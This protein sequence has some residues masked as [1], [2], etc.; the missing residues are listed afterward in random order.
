M[1]TI[2][3][4]GKISNMPKAEYTAKFESARKIIEQQGYEVINPVQI[5]EEKYGEGVQLVTWEQCM[6]DVLPYLLQADAVVLLPCWVHSRGAKIEFR[7]AKEL[8]IPCLESYKEL[9]LRF[10]EKLY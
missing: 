8:G 10:Y 5:I 6:K 3:I 2:Y 1:K 4:A 7:L 9:S